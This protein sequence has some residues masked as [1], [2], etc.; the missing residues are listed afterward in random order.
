[1]EAQNLAGT[2]VTEL[3]AMIDLA[4]E[5][6]QEYMMQKKMATDLHSELSQMQ[7]K[8]IDTLEALG[9]TGFDSTTCKFSYS[10]RESF[11]TPKTR[12]EKQELSNYMQSKYGAD[13]FWTY[14]SVNSRTLQ[15]FAKEELEQA[16]EKDDYNF[17]LPGCVRTTSDPVASMR[18][19]GK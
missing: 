7:G 14:F 11:Q 6:K 16:E 3:N 12:E 17:E 13:A 19:T 15:T 5:K 9:R 10:H 18:A 2:T 1:M 8:I 4:F